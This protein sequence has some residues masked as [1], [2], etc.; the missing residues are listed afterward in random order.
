M[1]GHTG[2][3]HVL[4]K[5]TVTKNLHMRYHIADPR[6]VFR[7]AEEPKHLVHRR[8]NLDRFFEVHRIFAFTESQ[9][10]P[11][12]LVRYRS[13]EQPETQRAQDHGRRRPARQAVG[14]QGR[15]Q[16]RADEPRAW[17]PVARSS[18]AP[19][20]WAALSRRLVPSFATNHST[21]RM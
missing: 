12:P 17:R 6:V 13:H 4:G 16:C 19:S 20:R 2:D 9:R 8:L 18:A 3:E 1:N 10:W 15:T 11:Q 21:D 7:M 14:H 5:P